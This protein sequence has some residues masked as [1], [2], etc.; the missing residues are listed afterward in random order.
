MTIIVGIGSIVG[1]LTCL[2]W[3]AAIR[4]VA[5]A[6]TFVVFAA[7]QILAFRLSLMP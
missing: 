2:R 3:R 7:L 1:L 4:P 5:A 6:T